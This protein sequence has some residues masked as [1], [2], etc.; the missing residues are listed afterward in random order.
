MKKI[1]LN[2]FMMAIVVTDF[3]GDLFAQSDL[4]TAAS[5]VIAEKSIMIDGAK[6][7]EAITGATFY[8]LNV[9]VAR[10]FIRHFKNLENTSWRELEGDYIAKFNS[11]DRFTLAWFNKAGKLYCTNYYGTAK[12]LP[13]EK[14]DLVQALYKD[15]EITATTE[16]RYKNVL[17]WVV[18]IQNG[19]FN[20]K[21][22][23]ADDDLIE[24][25]SLIRVK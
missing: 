3:T 12:H 5:P 6:N 8:N 19:N 25:E 10:S 23:I 15:Y 22:K 13:A 21:L 20:K 7:T 18:T 9:K 17:T 2:G 24:I 14:K 4:L 1:L 11:G 16:I